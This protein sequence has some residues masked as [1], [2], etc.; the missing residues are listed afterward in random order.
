M[1][2][3]EWDEAKIR[4]NIQLHGVDLADPVD[5]VRCMLPLYIA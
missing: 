1:L 4:L 2:K 3:S 5:K